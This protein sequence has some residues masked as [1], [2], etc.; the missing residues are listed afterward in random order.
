MVLYFNCAKAR[1]KEKSTVEKILYYSA[2]LD[3]G[4]PR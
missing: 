4:K 1:P 3:S 2:T